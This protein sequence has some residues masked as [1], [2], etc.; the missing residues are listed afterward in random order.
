MARAHERREARFLFLLQA[1]PHEITDREHDG[2]GD[3]VVGVQAFP[4]GC[5]YP[6]APEERKVLRDIGLPGG[7]FL[8]QLGDGLFSVVQGAQ[9]PEPSRLDCLAAWLLGRLGR[10]AEARPPLED[11]SAG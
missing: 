4:S 10:A 5:D 8:D 11:G 3:S 6:A 7:D 2:V 9:E 1:L